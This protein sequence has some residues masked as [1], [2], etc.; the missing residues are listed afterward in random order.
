IFLL[1]PMEEF[2]G[3]WA[4]PIFYSG[5]LGIEAEGSRLLSFWLGFELKFGR[6][7]SSLV[8]P[9]LHLGRQG[10]EV[11]VLPQGFPWG[12]LILTR[13]PVNPLYLLAFLMILAVR[14]PVRKW[15][16]P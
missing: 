12:Y 9:E 2:F 7:W 6:V 4:E 15:A 11:E 13:E 14:L 3:E 5:L 10:V 1:A 16:D 8:E